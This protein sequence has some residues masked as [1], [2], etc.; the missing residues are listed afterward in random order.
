MSVTFHFDD[1]ILRIGQS[2]LFDTDAYLRTIG[3]A[4]R[5]PSYVRGMPTL[6]DARGLTEPATNE[7]RLRIREALNGEAFRAFRPRRYAI[8]SLHPESEK[9]VKLA[10]ILIVDAL[11]G[12]S[13][14]ELRHF[15]EIDAA[16]AWVR[17]NA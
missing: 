9:L 11:E 7:D 2:G 4:V 16:E 1:G 17:A 5:N 10:T 3:E 15:S 13:R 14:T 6:V 12:G 8:V